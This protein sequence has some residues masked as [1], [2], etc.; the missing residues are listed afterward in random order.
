[1]RALVIVLVALT[2][3]PAALAD[4]PWSAPARVPGSGGPVYDMWFPDAG[5]G[6]LAAW[7]CGGFGAGHVAGTRIAAGRPGDS[8]GAWRTV[9]RK[10]STMAIAGTGSRRFAFGDMSGRATEEV[11]AVVRLTTQGISRP[12]P[13]FPRDTVSGELARLPDGHVAVVGQVSVSTKNPRT[14]RSVYLS[15]RRPGHGFPKATKLAGKGDR[16]W[17]GVAVNERGDALAAWARNGGVFVRERFANGRLG[18]TQ[19]IATDPIAAYL[20]L[21]LAPDGGAAVAWMSAALESTDPQPL[22]LVLRRAGGR[23]GALHTLET[24]ASAEP[25]R[26]AAYPDGRIQ[27]AWLGLDAAGSVVRAAQASGTTLTPPQTVSG[28]GAQDLRLATGPSGEAVLSWMDGPDASD[29]HMRAAVQ[30]AG[31]ASFGAPETIAGGAQC[32]INSLALD[33]KSGRAVVAWSP[34]DPPNPPTYTASRA[35]IR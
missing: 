35:P 30:P 31:A 9:S 10:I 15:V 17:L 5:P 25:V 26:L 16:A 1:M 2:L 34:G 22:R 13:I 23:F 11:V 29:S 6:A 4:G 3:A 12:L 32:C 33:P 21:A 7:C 20:T 8:F 28:S 18:R 19:R 24:V 14:R 27:L